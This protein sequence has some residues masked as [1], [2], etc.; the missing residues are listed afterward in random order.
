MWRFIGF[1]LPILITTVNCLAQNATLS[2]TV[3]DPQD[4]IVP[5]ALVSL[6]DLGKASSVKTVNNQAGIY[7][8][9]TLRPEAIRCASNRPDF[10]STR[11]HP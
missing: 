6:T 8:F 11:S 4:A 3:K 1:T 9:A 2:S 10:R 5:A 7:E